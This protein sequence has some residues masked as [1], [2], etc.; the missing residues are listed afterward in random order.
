MRAFLIFVPVWLLSGAALA[1]GPG[2]GTWSPPEQ[3]DRTQE[4]VDELRQLI[5]RADRFRAADPTFL[6]DLRDLARHYDRP[7]RVR[8][9]ADDFADGD[10][11]SNPA[12]TVSSG[13][14][15]IDWGSG[16]RSRVQAPPETSGESRRREEPGD[17]AA[18][19]IGT[20]LE[21]MARERRGSTQQTAEPRA[22]TIST[23]VQITNAFSIR[24]AL[25]SREGR[26]ELDLGPYGGANR[27]AGYRL[28]YSPTA[29]PALRLLRATGRGTS[30][31]ELYGDEMRLEDGNV[32][33]FEW[34]RDG[35]GEMVVRVDGTE[36]IRT[37]DRGFASAFDGF[38][39][40]N[41]GGDY[42]LHEITIYGTE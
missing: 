18:L 40:S 28:S 12:W 31:I 16:L 3:K 32:H 36:V 11:T 1:Q 19:I 29:S 6:R 38:V 25:S 4:M 34:T 24:L 42:T 8:L 9:L 26:G 14:F 41:R 37:L 33:I 21:R 13:A 35:A 30:V 5:D 17:T 39:L 23:Q 2:Y 20:L 27:E 7:W 10:F 22:A 15:W